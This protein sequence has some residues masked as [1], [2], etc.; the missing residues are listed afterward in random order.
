[1]RV[2]I[3]D[4]SL[5]TKKAS[6]G[7]SQP[8][9]GLWRGITESCTWAISRT[10]K[11]KLQVAKISGNSLLWFTIVVW[12]SRRKRR[13]VYYSGRAYFQRYRPW[14]SALPIRK[15]RILIFTDW[16]HHQRK[17]R[18][19]HF[20]DCSKNILRKATETPSREDIKEL[21]FQHP[22]MFPVFRPQSSAVQP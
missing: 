3:K 5:Y 7:D 11:S 22:H 2:H 12:L 14:G 4:S 16:I 9:M 1:M 19:N 20:A 6:G 13:Q 10:M 18:S 17:M 15:K 21:L 8:R